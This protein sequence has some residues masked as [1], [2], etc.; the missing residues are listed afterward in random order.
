MPVLNVT[1]DRR[2]YVYTLADSRDGEVFY[3]GKGCGKRMHQHEAEYRR[4][5][6]TNADK[7]LRIADIIENGG[8]VIARK[9]SSG[10]TNAE[11]LKQERRLIGKLGFS[12]LSNMMPGQYS[13][14]E[15]SKLRAAASLR[16]LKDRDDW[17]SEAPRSP[18]QIRLFDLVRQNLEAIAR[19]GWPTEIIFS[20]GAVS[21]R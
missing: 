9:V 6:I 13:G 7:H 12:E 10:L 8:K 2:Y 11:A 20:N 4:G 18:D 16:Q 5:K 3:V 21:F 14:I 19:D 17:L 15:K 1:E